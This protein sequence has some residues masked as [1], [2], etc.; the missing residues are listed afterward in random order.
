[1]LEVDL[2]RLR[3]EHRLSLAE[4]VP[5][6]AQL[7]G[8]ARIELAGP[9]HVELEA[10][11]AGP[12]VVVRGELR[13]SVAGQ[14]RRCLEP[15]VLEITEPVSA[16][17]TDAVQADDADGEVYALPARARM[18]DLSGMV[19]ENFLLAVPQFAVC[20]EGCRGLCPHCGANLNERDC[21]CD[22]EQADDRW[23]PLR[24]MKL[25]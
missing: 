10:Q 24:K 3:S 15:L 4:S 9:L 16:L 17:F 1:M 21:D 8:D 25:D 22:V 18:L 11:M 7:F 2:A 5:A 20:D 14:C 23:A 12:D 13:G 6:D 19:R